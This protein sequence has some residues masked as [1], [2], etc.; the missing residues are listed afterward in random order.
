M[1]VVEEEDLV[2]DESIDQESDESEKNEE[3]QDTEMDQESDSIPDEK[4]DDDDE[5]TVSVEGEDEKEDEKEEAPKWVKELRKKA[6]EQD[7]K[8][9]EYE[10]LLAEK[11]TVE[12][13]GKK[14]TLSDLDYD[15]DALAEALIAW[16]ERKRLNDEQKKNQ[17]KE[18]D[19]QTKA[20]NEKLSHYEDSKKSLGIKD[21]QEIEEDVMSVLDVTQQGVIIQGAKNPA[22][23]FYAIGK[24]DE[25][26]KKLSSIKDPVKFIW[27][28]AQIEKGMKVEKRSVATAPEKTVSGKSIA[29]SRYDSK[30]ESLEKEADKTGDRSKLIAYKRSIRT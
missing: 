13:V 14:P 9:K 1:V 21:F 18:L 2:V 7:R 8:L 10:Q 4:E 3:V 28:V 16:S 12:E 11:K 19:E 29:N 25:R 17:Q 15:E 27:E 26:L 20:W 30:L 24:N 23:L 22:A 6:R 5:F